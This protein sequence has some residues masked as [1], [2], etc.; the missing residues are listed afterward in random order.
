MAGRN[1]ETAKNGSGSEVYEADGSL[2][3]GVLVGTVMS[4]PVWA[5][6]LWV[7]IC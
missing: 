7:L 4:A 3:M 6:V 2:F 5:L 1:D